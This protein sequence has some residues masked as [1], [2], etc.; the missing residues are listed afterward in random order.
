MFYY[1]GAR[2]APKAPCAEPHRQ[3][4]GMKEGTLWK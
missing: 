1:S 3:A 2:K 4:N